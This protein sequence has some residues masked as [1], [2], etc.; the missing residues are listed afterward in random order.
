MSNWEFTKTGQANFAKSNL[1]REEKEGIDKYVD[2][3]AKLAVSSIDIERPKID[4]LSVVMCPLLAQL[5]TGFFSIFFAAAV[6]STTEQT[7]Q[8]LSSL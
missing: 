4:C 8:A 3:R 6:Y 1:E 7:R 2:K 5:K